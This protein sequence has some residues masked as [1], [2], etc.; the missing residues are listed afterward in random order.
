MVWEESSNLNIKE[1]VFVSN[2]N[3]RNYSIVVYF[4]NETIYYGGCILLCYLWCQHLLFTKYK[5]DI[6]SWLEYNTVSCIQEKEIK[7]Q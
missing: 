7:P 6:K 3:N 2:D 5:Y 4:T 1:P